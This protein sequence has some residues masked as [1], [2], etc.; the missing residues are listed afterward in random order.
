LDFP[1][2]YAILDADVVSARGLT[3]LDVVGAWL[4]AGVR[5]IQLRAK[6]M[7]GGPFL[8]LADRVQQRVQQAGGSLIINDRAD[9]ARMSGA[10]GVHVGQTDLTPRDVRTVIGRERVLGLS[11]HDSDQLVAGTREDVSYLAIGP[12]FPTATNR[13][14]GKAVDPAV[15][16]EGVHAAAARLTGSRLPLVAIGGITLERAPEVL[17]AGA[18]SV[19]VISDLLVGTPESRARAFVTALT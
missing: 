4:S 14:T 7:D 19:A 2:L 16:L 10:A 8:D 11:T 5:L 13:K 3:A 9:I 6:N 1:R 12:V 17:A 15:G 18:A